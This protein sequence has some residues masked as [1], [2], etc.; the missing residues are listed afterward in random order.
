LDEDF[1]GTLRFDDTQVSVN[2]AQ[3]KVSLKVLREEGSDGKISCI[4]RTEAMEATK[5]IGCKN[6]AEFEDYLPYH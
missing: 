6:A 2:K 1:P 5:G 3:G 4:V